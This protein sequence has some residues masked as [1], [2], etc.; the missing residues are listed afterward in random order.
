M[1]TAT[2]AIVQQD[3]AA[4]ECSRILLPSDLLLSTSSWEM[5]HTPKHAVVASAPEGRR[6]DCG[7]RC[8]CAPC[9]LPRRLVRTHAQTTDSLEIVL[10]A[11]STGL[12]QHRS[13]ACR[14]V[15]R[16]ACVTKLRL[17]T[18]TCCPVRRGLVRYTSRSRP[19]PLATCGD[20]PVRVRRRIPRA[21]HNASE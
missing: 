17:A 12:A 5:E 19:M 10:A 11:G 16:I 3:D 15:V 2:A 20:L 18:F 14:V 9:V 7:W 1:P 8:R 21:R 6:H 4:D 13:R